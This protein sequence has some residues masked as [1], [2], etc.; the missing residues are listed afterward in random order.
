MPR[1]RRGPKSS[2]NQVCSL[3]EGQIVRR[4]VGFRLALAR[5]DRLFALVIQN[6]VAHK[7]G[8]GH[9]GDA[10][11]AVSCETTTSLVPITPSGVDSAVVR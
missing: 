1:L 3:D 4:T 11:P 6:E 8:L 7:D 5:H 9:P 2:V 10:G